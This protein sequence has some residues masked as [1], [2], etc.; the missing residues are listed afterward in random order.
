MIAIHNEQ[1]S[2]VLTLF[3]TVP[4]WK[5]AYFSAIENGFEEILIDDLNNPSVAVLFFGGLVVYAGDYS[6]KAAREIVKAFREQ[7]LILGY[8]EGWNK[9]LINEYGNRLTKEKRYYLSYE[10]FDTEILRSNTYQNS[11]IKVESCTVEDY[12]RLEAALTWEHQKYHYKDVTDFIEHSFTYLAKDNT[13][14]LSGASAFIRSKKHAECQI[15]TI[16]QMQK[17][18][19]AKIVGTAFIKKCL[20]YEVEIPWDAANAESVRLGKYF[21]YRDVEQYD[22]YSLHE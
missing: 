19:L 2:K 22:V 16:K 3:S 20:E 10:K 13:A 9:V 7:P 5:A 8:S 1:R 18:G 15:N 14:I 12:V 4:K 6:C 17:L 21:G 11:Q